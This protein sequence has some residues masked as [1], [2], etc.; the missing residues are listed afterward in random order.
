MGVEKP[1]KNR[2]RLSLEQRLGV[3]QMRE[4]RTLISR[5]ALTGSYSPLAWLT[6]A[7][8]LPFVAA[9]NFPD[10]EVRS[11]FGLGDLELLGRALFY[12]DRSFS[13]RHL[14]GVLVGI[15]TPTGPRRN[16]STGYPAPDDQQPGSGSWDGQFGLS[17]SYFGDA[18]AAF[19]SASYRLTSIGYRGYQRGG[20]LG[21][22]A[23]AQFPIGRSVAVSAG[24]EFSH[25]QRSLLPEGATAP[26]TGGSL[27]SVSQ[28]LLVSL[29]QDW[30]LRFTIQTPVL[31]AFYGLQRETPTGVLALIVDI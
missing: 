4:E 2:I 30:L 18:L 23:L 19:L 7:A 21:V 31:Q 10:G 24:L 17:Y 8:L 26:D 16:D 14:A 12:R 3:H 28:G 6:F 27:L 9:V 1:F 20:V 29:R 11:V 25:T 15:K 13:P 22:T 5:T